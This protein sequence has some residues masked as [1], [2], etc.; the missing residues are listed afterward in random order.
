MTLTRRDDS[1]TSVS[2]PDDEAAVSLIVG[3]VDVPV[4]RMGGTVRTVACRQR[5][6][7]PSWRQSHFRWASLLQMIYSNTQWIASDQP[8]KHSGQFDEAL[9]M[10]GRSRP[11]ERRVPDKH[12]MC[13]HLCRPSDGTRTVVNHQ[14]VCRRDAEISE[15]ALVVLWPL[16]QGSDQIRAI[17]ATETVAYPHGLQVADQIE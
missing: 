7:V 14:R 4:E 11:R 17:E 12:R 15:H 13:P 10:Y 5:H 3:S 16:F 9:N 2:C 6:R 1:T 8:L